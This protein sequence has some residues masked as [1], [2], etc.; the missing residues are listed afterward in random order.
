MVIKNGDTPDADVLMILLLSLASVV[1]VGTVRPV[2]PNIVIWIKTDEAPG[3]QVA[4]KNTDGFR[5][6]MTGGLI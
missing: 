2:D 1:S 3:M 6:V 4:I 5:I